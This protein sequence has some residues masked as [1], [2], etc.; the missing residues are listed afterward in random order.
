MPLRGPFRKPLPHG[1]CLLPSLNPNVFSRKTRYT[2]GESEFVL[3]SS[4]TESNKAQR[5]INKVQFPGPFG[6]RACA[7]V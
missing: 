3:F 5:K 2:M 7:F 1:L 4:L 6:V